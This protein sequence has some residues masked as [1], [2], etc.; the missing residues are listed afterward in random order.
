MST[1]SSHILVLLNIFQSSVIPGRD[2]LQQYHKELEE[3]FSDGSAT[4]F[5][6]LV[7]LDN[8]LLF[9]QGLLTVGEKYVN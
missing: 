3:K 4:K 1:N 7:Q 2:V 5:S 8:S 6:D 9:S